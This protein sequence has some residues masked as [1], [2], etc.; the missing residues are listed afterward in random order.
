VFP[1]GPSEQDGKGAVEV[2]QKYFQRLLSVGPEQENIV[3]IAKLG[4]EFARYGAEVLGRQG[5]HEKVGV[6]RDH[7]STHGCAFD[8]QEIVVLKGEVVRGE[9]KLG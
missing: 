5:S 9:D 8:L 2:L 6:G 4:E 3:D 1:R 7:A